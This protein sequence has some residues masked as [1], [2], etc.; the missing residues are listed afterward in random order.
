MKIELTTLN[1]TKNIQIN[2]VISALKTDKEKAV[3]VGNEKKANDCWLELEILKL[4][5]LFIQAFHNIKSQNYREAWEELEKCE[6][7]YGF[8]SNNATEDLLNSSKLEFIK[9]K[10]PKLQ[11]L[12]PYCMFISP[13]FKV[14]YYTCSICDHKVRP[15]SRC[16]HKKGK[17]YNG[18]VCLHVVH[19][20]EMLEISIV[21]K[22]VQKYS[23]MHDDSTLDFTLLNSL[24]KYLNNA[25]EYWDLDRT[26]RK[27]PIDRFGSVAES[28]N[29]PCQ[30]EKTFQDCCIEKEEIEI[31]HIDFMFSKSL[32]KESKIITFPY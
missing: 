10:V 27:F 3:Q 24:F 16:E 8:I 21:T 17:V 5:I 9:D 28:E 15:R 2:Q 13:G 23:V 1:D 18:E 20:I 29:C 19:D 11:S 30:S 31:P 25:F 32:P 26:T 12:Y 7:K 4:N 6:I 14:G 22:P